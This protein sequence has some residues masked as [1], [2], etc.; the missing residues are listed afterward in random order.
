MIRAWKQGDRRGARVLVV[1]PGEGELER[2]ARGLEASGVQVLSLR[3]AGVLI[4]VATAFRP[5]LV[6]VATRAPELAS[7][8]MARRLHQK[9][10]GAVPIL[11]VIDAPDPELRRRCLI[12]GL[13]MDV[14]SRPLDEVEVVTK[15]GRWLRHDA[16]VERA[17]RNAFELPGP[18]LRDPLTGAYNRRWLLSLLAQEI[19]RAERYGGSF[20]I[21]AVRVLGFGPLER[22]LG[23]A[24]TDPLLVQV[25]ALL[26]EG[27]R[28]ADAVA[29][30]GTEELAVFLPGTSAEAL[31][32]LR[33]RLMERFERAR[34]ALGGQWVRPR[35][36]LGA[37]SFPEILGAPAR[38]VSAAFEE[39]ERS[40][41]G[42]K[43]GAVRLSG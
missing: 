33:A 24:G 31:A 42:V 5:H 2:V 4:P 43:V 27:V 29:R 35:V 8:E 26:S 15:V 17:G 18:T 10:H 32:P 34:V 7:L 41:H 14:L 28:E 38:L 1:G 16:Q 9:T 11:Y 37:A 6:I 13:G 30:V 12:K 21:L 19:R 23:R 36:A 39:L 40:R 3:R 20:S 22:A 25:S